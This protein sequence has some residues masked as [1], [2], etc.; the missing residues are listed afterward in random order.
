MSTFYDM[1]GKPIADVTTWAQQFEHANRQIGVTRIPKLL[2][3][4]TVWL[5]LDHDF[6]FYMR[7]GRNAVNPHPLQFETMIFIRGV[8]VDMTRWRS[9]EEA[10]AGHR[11]VVRTCLLHPIELWKS[12]REEVKDRVK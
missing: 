4:S 2:L 9:L 8:S 7:R 12:Y 5:G 11:A 1:N 10:K 6:A 3:I